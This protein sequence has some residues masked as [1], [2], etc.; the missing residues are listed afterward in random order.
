MLAFGG[1]CFIDNLPNS[2][3]MYLMKDKERLV[4]LA[5]MYLIDHFKKMVFHIDSSG[6]MCF[7]PCE[8]CFQAS[9]FSWKHRD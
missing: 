2:M 5:D 8:G 3:Q 1:V 6:F 9:Q 4:R 7:L